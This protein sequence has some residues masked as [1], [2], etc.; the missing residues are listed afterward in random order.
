MKTVLL[1]FVYAVTFCVLATKYAT[2]IRTI[3]VMFM[4]KWA[5]TFNAFES[6]IIIIT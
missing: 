2:A 1:A 6:A 4:T 5:G 3:V